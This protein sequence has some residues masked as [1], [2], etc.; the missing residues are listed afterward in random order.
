MTGV[1][2]VRVRTFAAWLVLTGSVAAWSG[3]AHL[4]CRYAVS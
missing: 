1:D 3:I 2:D 4:V